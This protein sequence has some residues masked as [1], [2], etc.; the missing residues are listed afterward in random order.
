[1]DEHARRR[2][3]AIEKALTA[4]GVEARA[5]PGS[6]VL[7]ATLPLGP[8]PFE[9]LEGPRRVPSVL[10]SALGGD[11]IKCLKPRMLF[12][13]PPISITDCPNGARLEARIRFT[14]KCHLEGLRRGQRW[15]RETGVAAEPAE[16]GSILTF[17]IGEV[18]PEARATL[19]EPG[20][21][22]L[23]SRGPLA[24]IALERAEDRSLELEESYAA[25]VDLEIAVSSRLSELEK[26]HTRLMAERRSSTAEVSTPPSAK[27]AAQ[28]SHNLLLV[29]PRL[30]RDRRFRDSLQV[31]GYRVHVASS[32]TE[33]LRTFD[34]ASPQL[35]L[36]EM[37]LG[38]SEGMELIPELRQLPGIEEVPVLLVDERL[39]EERREVARRVGAAGYLVHPVD[40]RKIAEGIANIVKKPKRRRFTRYGSR[41]SVSCENA[42]RG[43]MLLWADRDVSIHSLGR[44]WISLPAL[45]ETLRTDAELIYRVRLPGTSQEGI[46]LCFKSFRDDDE[47]L[48]ISYLSSLEQAPATA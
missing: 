19:A 38:R 8:E 13:L 31:R 24:G 35:V 25:A 23:P 20:R 42:A 37:N 39:R 16:E 4:M 26:L 22:L 14:W 6:G 3:Q 2:R 36:A 34:S 27:P 40:V 21:L 30:V 12:Q 32:A 17:P 15:L 9:T 44:Y 1:M 47:S 10:F 11:R 33:A 41:L 18:H 48:L 29:G 7:V 28:P 5:L 43:G 46:G 45:D